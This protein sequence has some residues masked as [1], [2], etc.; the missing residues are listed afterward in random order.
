[1]SHIEWISVKQASDL[2]G[3]DIEYLRQMIRKKRIRAEK[4][5]GMRE[6][7]VDKASLQAYVRQMKQLGT[8][9][10]NPFRK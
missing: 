1:M 3:Y 2:S 7:L 4:F 6:W 8:D 9:K 10:F 5:P